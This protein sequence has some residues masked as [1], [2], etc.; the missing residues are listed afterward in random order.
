MTLSIG[1]GITIGGGITFSKPPL[2]PVTAG[3]QVNLDAATYSGTG[4]WIDSVNSA[5]YALFNNPDY[6]SSIG[7]GSFGFVPSSTQYAYC[8]SPLPTLTNW[9]VEAWHYYDG[10]WT[11]SQ[12]C[13]VSQQFTG[14]I[15]FALGSLGVSAPLLQAGFFNG[16]WQVETAQTLTP[17][18][19]Y[20]IV[21]ICSNTDV[22]LC[23]NGVGVAGAAWSGTPPA[24]SGTGTYLMHRWD[25]AD[26][27]GGRLG[28][29]R[30]YDRDIGPVDLLQNFNADRAR[31]GL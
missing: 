5:E 21:G 20:Q 13:I 17:G 22:T 14:T 11:G 23:I 25:S 31:F 1:T 28:I 29:V 18:N 16:G 15:N 3:L 7:G 24:S 26:C 4:P 2:Q 9:T 12:P 19:W 10:T 27:W 6:S 8:S 30:I